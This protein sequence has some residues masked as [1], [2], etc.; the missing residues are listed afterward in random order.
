MPTLNT[1]YHVTDKPVTLTVVIGDGQLGS[2]YVQLDGTKI[3]SGEKISNFTIGAGVQIKGKV[4]RI[5]SI[6][7][8]VNDMTNHTSISY[9]LKGGVKDATYALEST[10]A[11]EGDSVL[12][13]AEIAFVS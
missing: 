3:T 12:Y 10:V 13:R 9:Q 8:D 5:K 2:S 4:L 1:E 6:V 7:S 11:N